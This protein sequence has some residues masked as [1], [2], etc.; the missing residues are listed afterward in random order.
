[1]KLE[2]LIGHQLKELAGADFRQKG[3]CIYLLR[4]AEDS[5]G[6]RVADDFKIL[7][8]LERHPDLATA[9]VRSAEMY[10]GQILLR[11]IWNK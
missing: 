1:M 11:V 5:V 9:T 6:V 10:Y 8:I 4:D 7:T 2:K 3:Y